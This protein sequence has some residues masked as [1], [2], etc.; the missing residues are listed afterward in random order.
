MSLIDHINKKSMELWHLQQCPLFRALE[1]QDLESV[2]NMT[3]MLSLG[4]DEP[5]TLPPSHLGEKCFWVIK[6][7]HIKLDYH[8]KTGRESTVMILGPGDLFGAFPT[9]GIEQYEEI[10]RTVTSVCLCI[11]THTD[12]ERLMGKHPNIAFEITKAAF[13]R[14]EKLQVRMADLLMKPIEER[15][16]I[17]LLQL[18]RQIGQ[19]DGRG[20]RMF[21]LPL[22]HRDLAN[23]VGSSR[24]MVTHVLRRFRSE[25]ILETARKELHLQRM[26][27]LEKLARGE[28]L[29]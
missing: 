27:L 2:F 18:N 20:G 23:L 24:E 9:S 8:D 15:L 10:A 17:T 11:I 6:R 26:D 16:A 21:A 19:D 14:I 22:S 29:N 7:G 12:F 13:R 3:Q 28:Q 1:D 4:P 5:V 25:G